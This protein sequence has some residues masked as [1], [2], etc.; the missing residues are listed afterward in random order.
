MRLFIAE[1]PELARAI[2]SAL[3]GN[4]KK[5]K[6]YIIKGDN[7]ITWAFGHILELAQP[8]IYDSK[9]EQWDINDLPLKIVDFIYVPKQDCKEQLKIICNLIQ[10]KDTTSIIHC[11]D[12]DDEGQILIDEILDYS[13]NK[14]PVFR[15]LIN[16]ITPKAIQ[17]EIA[18]ML[19]NDNFKGMSERGFA[20]SQADY[21]VGINL[22]RAYTCLARQN[23]YKGKSPISLG[24]V[25]TPI[26]GLIVSRDTMQETFQSI[27][28]F[29]LD[30]TFTINNIT[31]QASLKTKEKIMLKDTI[32]IISNECN[33]KEFN[34]S[35]LKENK[36]EYPPLPYNLLI[37]QAECAKNLGLKP[38]EVLS[39]TQRLREQYQLITYNRSDCQYLPETKFDE[40]KDIIKSIGENISSNEFNNLIQHADLSIK[41]K[42]FNDSNLSAHYGIIPTT[43]TAD[44]TKLQHLEKII[45]EMIA[46]RFLCQFYPPK[47]YIHTQITLTYKDYEF[48]ASS[49]TTL[50][51]GY[52]SFFGVNQNNKQTNEENTISDNNND[53]SIIKEN[54][55]AICTGT[56]IEKRQTKPKPHYT[57]ETLLKDLTSVAKYVSNERIRQLLIERDKDKKGEH[58]GIGTPATRSEHIKKLID[59]GYIEV[60]NDKKQIIKAT[61]KGKNLINI[62]PNSLV[63]ID[64]TALWFEQQKMIEN[65]EITRSQFLESVLKQIEYEIQKIQTDNN[66]TILS[67]EK[68]NMA[69][70]A[71]K[72]KKY[73]KKP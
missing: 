16:D 69:Y 49:N 39:I 28:Y 14:K 2:A 68:I 54:L 18:K 30:A 34:Y 12:A 61:Q 42:A 60:S 24:R 32:E 48:Y 37:L 36:K 58:G 19:P 31:L 1:K 26:L 33:K 22:T 67:D 46:K 53:L 64:L 6:G 71:L 50:K 41:S 44:F 8:H 59:R 72:L 45:Y 23:G 11:G 25:Q 15:V 3:N 21:L 65:N 10:S 52:S 38:D 47:E 40:A 66:F 63:A 43:A 20:R 55:K 51:V 56:N 29:T 9:Y 27:D 7:I 70:K 57:M 35:I 5:A 13:K 17:H 4:E 62:A 73:R